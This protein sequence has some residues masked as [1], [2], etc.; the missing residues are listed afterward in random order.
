MTA[1]TAHESRML[2]ALQVAADQLEAERQ[3]RRSPI[4]IVG[5]ACRLPGADSPEA[6]W[7]LLAAGGDAVGPLS[8]YR[9]ADAGEQLPGGYLERVDLFD[10]VPFGL[11]PREVA[12]MDPQHRLLLETAQDAFAAAGWTRAALRD[13][14]TG[15][16]VG[17]TN[18]DYARLLGRSGAIDNYFVTGNT[19]N[20]AA[21]RISYLFGLRGPALAVDTACSSSLVAVHL[22]CQSLRSDDCRAAVVGGVNLILAC[23]ATRGLA[24]AGVLSADGRC[25]TFDAQAAGMGRGEG[26][27]V[28][29]LKRL[30][31]AE[32]DGDRVLAVIR[33]SAVNQD[34]ACGGL[35][36]P[37]GPAQEAVI[38]RALADAGLAPDAID[39]I[40]AHGTGTPLGDPIEMAALARVFNPGRAAGRPLRV[41][42]IKTNIAHGESSAGM[43]GLIK[44]VLCLQHE[45]MA[46]LAGLTARSPLIEWV[47]GLDVP[48]SLLPWPRGGRQRSAGVSGFGLS[49]TNAHIVVTEAPA[50]QGCAAAS[51][52]QA[53]AVA[54]PVVLPLSA[55]SAVGLAALAAAY[56]QRLDAGVVPLASLARTAALARD[57]WPERLA[58]VAV[59][60]DAARSALAIAASGGHSPDVLRG[61]A[62]PGQGGAVAFLFS[63]QGTQAERM[64]LELMD[65]EPVFAQAL[66]E[67]A[68]LLGRD[69]LAQL[70][71]DPHGTAQAQPALLAYQV[72]LLAWWRARGVVPAAVLGHSVGEFAA[73]W[74]AGVMT[75][76]EALALVA[77]R[78]RLMSGLPRVGKMVALHVPLDQVLAVLARHQG[79]ALAAANA[80]GNQVV[81]GATDAVDA[82]V[83]E[84]RAQGVRCSPLAVSHAFHSP[85][86]APMVAPF[87]ELLSRVT[88]CPPQLPFFSGMLGR[89]ADAEVTRVDY[90]ADHI[91]CPV[92]FASA[93]GAVRAHGARCFLEIGPG[94]TLCGLGRASPGGDAAAWIASQRP[95]SV[96]QKSLYR[97]LGELHCAG[98]DID[99]SRAPGDGCDPALLPGYPWDRRT[100]WFQPAASMA[101][102][103]LAGH[104]ALQWQEQPL[105]EPAAT[106]APATRWVL[107]RDAAGLA[108]ALATGLQARGV[109]AQVLEAGAACADTFAQGMAGTTNLV[110]CAA[111]DADDAQ[112]WQAAQSGGVLAALSLLQRSPRTRVWLLTRQGQSVAGE[113]PHLQ[114]AALWGLG[115]VAALERPSCWGGLID[116]DGAVDVAALVDELL[117]GEGGEVAWRGAR[118]LVPR[119]QAAAAP[120]AV[121]RLSPSRSYLLTGAYGG[122]GLHSLQWL[123]A[124]GAR[125]LVLCG[126]G[127]P[128]A[129]ASAAIA[130]AASLWGARIVTLR[131]DL[132]EMAGAQHM[133]A[134]AEALGPLGGIVHA[135]GVIDDALLADQDP[136]R[137]DRAMAGK[138]RGALHL[139]V[140][141]QGRA[142]DLFVLFSSLSSVLGSPGQANYAAANA[143]L[144]ALA[145][146]R[147]ARGDVATSVNWGPWAGAGMAV[148]HQETLR[149]R[150]LSVWEAPDALAM[151]G[152]LVAARSVRAVLAL[153]QPEVMRQAFPLARL[154]MLDAL[155]P[156]AEVAA[157][158]MA[159]PQDAQ[160]AA[161]YLV[162]AMAPVLG[163]APGWSPVP[164][165]SLQAQ[166]ID[167]MMATELRNRIQRDFGVELPLSAFLGGATPQSLVAEF[168][169]QLALAALSAQPP[170]ISSEDI[171]L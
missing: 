158:P 18:A 162:Q 69:P 82:V 127:E 141:T 86:M 37:N 57:P 73:A 51:A 133:I 151:L 168:M 101:A 165:L 71:G 124:C 169:R 62:P 65:T 95:G 90:W 67:S 25:H 3:W 16:F 135:A 167:S 53:A 89:R 132:A 153:M 85:L 136:A 42:S 161:A 81:S 46:P 74:A 12:S 28:V 20:A 143:M 171:L 156:P 163:S 11:S 56:A 64:G 157:A 123:L 91:L 39:H 144:D 152:R 118:R 22:A 145:G 58:L 52:D 8:A 126:R 155:A 159:R 10:P 84:L 7:E 1:S 45:A 15:V 80:P 48:R 76:S 106:P 75:L 40:E 21:G 35:T 33:G 26:C 6:L 111:M 31:D 109:S 60:A 49:G 98:A 29:L 19:L 115:R 9:A 94:A 47:D 107:T 2:R 83:T 23:D 117:H 142:L 121:L 44:T 72:A 164:M 150:G 66:A 77:E 148:R 146:A 92:E 4:A 166:G 119:L 129:E 87:R 34:G 140:L 24:E 70:P 104:Y 122:L 131:A 134:A 27:G 110:D 36:V 54:A 32:R 5:M 93:L 130:Q 102:P 105:P 137:F 13:S 41:G 88:L 78:G 108:L 112:P 147:Q 59:D 55:G 43:A 170:G 100:F 38:R 114:Q 160:Q 50:T 17:I 116:V 96:E 14:P 113:S 30:A 61:V 125:R 128:S 120:G 138:V 149:G 99:W 68:A 154:A 103:A 63:G 97:A 79:V 139:D